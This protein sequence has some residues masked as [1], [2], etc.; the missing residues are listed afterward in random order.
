MAAR[1]FANNNKGVDE[2]C[3]EIRAISQQSTEWALALIT[4]GLCCCKSNV[5]GALRYTGAM[6]NQGVHV[7]PFAVSVLFKAAAEVNR[8]KDAFEACRGGIITTPYVTITRASQTASAAVIRTR[9]G[10]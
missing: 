8:V 1:T 3:E 2:I 9:F 7:P 6:H 5:R 4:Q 10:H